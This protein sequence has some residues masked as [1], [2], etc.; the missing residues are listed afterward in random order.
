[1]HTLS[2]AV[3]SRKCWIACG[4][5]MKWI[6]LIVASIWLNWNVS[7][8]WQKSLPYRPVPFGMGKPALD[9]IDRWMSN[10]LRGRN[11]R[12]AAP[13]SGC[14]E[15]QTHLIAGRA[16]LYAFNGK[17]DHN[18]VRC[19]LQYIWSD[20]VRWQPSMSVPGG[21]TAIIDP[22]NVLPLILRICFIKVSFDIPRDAFTFV[23]FAQQTHH[24]SDA[25][26]CSNCKRHKFPLEGH[27]SSDIQQADPEPEFVQSG[28]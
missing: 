13:A 23:H 18:A 12:T 8:P 22:A 17:R 28:L 3:E 2:L 19:G 10:D 20:Y 27:V 7:T 26:G 16:A 9:R 6:L 5:I 4:L 21:S 24:H 14:R 11:V 15:V 25:D 1:M